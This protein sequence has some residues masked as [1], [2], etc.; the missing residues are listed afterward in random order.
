M[1]IILSPPRPVVDNDQPITIIQI[2]K[3]IIPNIF[4][5]TTLANIKS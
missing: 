1:V 2:T 3:R 4:G 5:L